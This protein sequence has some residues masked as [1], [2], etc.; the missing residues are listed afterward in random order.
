MRQPAGH[1]IPSRPILRPRA[2]LIGI[3]ILGLIVVGVALGRIAGFG[4][5]VPPAGLPLAARALTFEDRADGSILVRDPVA[6]T[7]VTEL[8]P[9]SNAFVRGTLRALVRERKLNE[10]GLGGEFRLAAW[11]DGR[12]TLTDPSTGR[13]LG[14]DA[15]GSNN[16]EAFA[17]LLLLREGAQ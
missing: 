5:P 14:L 1:P 9:G 3:G 13:M 4:T 7:A 11:P 8:E 12:L 10:L 15:F 2:P 17:R 16:R 6:G